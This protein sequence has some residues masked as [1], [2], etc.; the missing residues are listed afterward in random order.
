MSTTTFAADPQRVFA[1]L[2]QV[3]AERGADIAPGASPHHL[4][5]RAYSHGKAK[6]NVLVARLT[7]TASLAAIAPDQTQVTLTCGIKVKDAWLQIVA[8]VIGAFAILSGL[9]QMGF[10]VDTRGLPPPPPAFSSGP[11]GGQGGTFDSTPRGGATFD[12]APQGGLADDRRLPSLPPPR[13]QGGSAEDAAGGP[14][15]LVV[16]GLAGAGLFGLFGHT[17]RRYREQVLAALRQRLAL[18]AAAGA[19]VPVPTPVP[20]AATAPAPQDAPD[21]PAQL[22]RLG[23]I[24]DE[25]LIT[26]DE[27]DAKRADIVARL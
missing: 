12:R 15:G 10:G 16:F 13:Q 25:G 23:Q 5:F 20:A 26:Q 24:R 3:L 4:A 21:L 17:P 11:G 18:P 7:G 19:P 8:V 9:A 14:L 6:G 2:Q 27:F 1:A 22:R